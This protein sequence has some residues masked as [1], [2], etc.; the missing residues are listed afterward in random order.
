MGKGSKEVEKNPILIPRAQLID[1]RS[2]Q[3][4]GWLCSGI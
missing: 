2:M 3:K 4:A 1:N